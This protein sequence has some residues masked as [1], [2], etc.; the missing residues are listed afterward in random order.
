MNSWVVWRQKRWATLRNLPEPDNAQ[1]PRMEGP[2]QSGGLRPGPAG[3][4]RD[5]ARPGAA[6][7]GDRTTA[8]RLPPAGLDALARQAMFLAMA[9]AANRML[10]L[11]DPPDAFVRFVGRAT[12][13][14][15]PAFVA[16]IDRLRA[17]G[18]R[19]FTF[20]LS[21]CP[22]MDSTFS[23][24][25][26]KFVLDLEK[27]DKPAGAEKAFTLVGAHA[28]VIELLDSLYILNLFELADKPAAPPPGESRWTEADATPAGR[29]AVNA[30]CLQ[31]HRL[32]RL[33]HPDNAARFKDVVRFLE[34]DAARRGVPT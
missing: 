9:E 7:C 30:C 29:D 8:G 12:A 2:F 19:R 21:E 13:Q 31:A 1:I 32:L 6:G 15:S 18:V 17:H 28:A 16:L 20:D 26:A 10:V 25:L 23:G 22:M 5:Q 33:L 4:R 3:C 11:E 27:E 14:S 34:E 24:A